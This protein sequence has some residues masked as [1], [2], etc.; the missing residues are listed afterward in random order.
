[1]NKF[2][3]TLFTPCYNSGK[4]IHRVFKSIDNFTFRDFEW[5]VVND[6]STDNTHQLI[7]DYIS[8]A[9]FHVNYLNRKENK[10]LHANYEYALE[11]CKGDFFLPMGH[12]DEWYPDTLETFEKLF[13]E[14]DDDQIAA[15]GALCKNQDG[16]L[17]DFEYPKNFQIAN[18]F[19]MFYETNR[20][21]KEVPF[22]YK[23]D[24]FKKY[25]NEKTNLNAIIGCN[26]NMIFIN[27][28][29]RVYYINENPTAL[30]K[31]SRKDGAL[32]M[33]YHY[34]YWVNKYQYKLGHAPIYR[35]RGVFAYP[36]HGILAKKQLKVMLKLIERR[37]NKLLV[38]VFYL[39]AL[40]LSKLV[41]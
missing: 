22:C 10:M 1:M 34:S 14:Y 29:V 25:F 24:I 2:R 35:W 5:I 6:A 27:K 11:H 17:V 32:E 28:I 20:Y 41:N 8:K 39:P 19:E 36:Y 31:G 18:Y 40:I 26:Y 16:K 21:R 38:L 12:D 3:F 37:E 15:I 33:F 23:T 4:F 7:T 13:R 9:D 30:S